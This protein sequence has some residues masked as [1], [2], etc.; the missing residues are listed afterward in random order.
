MYCVKI[1]TTKL[2]AW[3]KKRKRDPEW[4]YRDVA[5]VTVTAEAETV[6]ELF[7]DGVDWDLVQEL[8][9]YVDLD[10]GEEVVPA[11]KIVNHGEYCVPGAIIDHRDGTVTIR[12]GKITAEEALAELKEALHG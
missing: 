3:V 6:K 12:M 8:A 4:N 2:P 1:G 10:I 9:P 7:A 11:P 5:E